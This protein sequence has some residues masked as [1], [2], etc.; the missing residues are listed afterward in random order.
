MPSLSSDSSESDILARVAVSGNKITQSV[1]H[2]YPISPG[3]DLIEK[4]MEDA[5]SKGIY[6]VHL[7]KGTHVL[8]K[9]F[10]TIKRPMTI[11]GAGRGIT[12]VKGGGFNIKGK[13]GKKCKFMDI[14]VH[15]TKYDGLHGYNGMSFDCIR[16]HFDQCGQHGVSVADMKGRLTNCQVT[17]SKYHGINCESG[18]TIEIAGEESMIENNCTG[19]E[20]WDYYGLSAAYRASIHILS[21]LTKG[22]ISTN[23][24][25]GNNYNNTVNIKTVN[26]FV[27]E[28]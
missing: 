20:S 14:T 5:I 1:G 6:S 17:Q 8:T 19:E 21:P 12:F 16:M 7:E 10:V 26:S 24:K 3:T 9:R 22:S 23:N 4:G 18:S 11:S 15:M 27:E 2:A 28:E 13:K 25:R